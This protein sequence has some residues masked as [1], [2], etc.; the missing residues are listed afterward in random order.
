MGEETLLRE[1]VEMAQQ[2]KL[3]EETLLRERVEMAQERQLQQEGLERT[4][5]EQSE[6]LKEVYQ[7][8]SM[9]REL[10]DA[11]SQK[12]MEFEEKKR[13]LEETFR[14]KERRLLQDFQ[15]KQI[16]LEEDALRKQSELN[17]VQRDRDFF[18]GQIRALE[19]RV[20]DLTLNAGP[21]QRA[22]HL[23]ERSLE[24]QRRMIVEEFSLKDQQYAERIGEEQEKWYDQLR[25]R[26]QELNRDRL[27]M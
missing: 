10:E 26:E 6:L 19:D 14:E 3:Q 1:R 21:G 20:E 7:E 4:L 25:K 16:Q 24:E 11:V 9:V 15:S 12:E 5:K 22:D 13:E 18:A 2:T 27:S 8:K 17:D 23:V